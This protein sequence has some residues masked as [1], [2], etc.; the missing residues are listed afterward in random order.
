MFF[1]CGMS[2]GKKLLDYTKTVICG[3]C[4]GYGRYQVFM[5]FRYVS[6]FFIPILNGTGIITFKCPAVIPFMN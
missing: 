4:G 6:V 3:L 2:Q 5:T 1:I